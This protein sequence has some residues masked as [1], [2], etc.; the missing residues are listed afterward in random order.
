LDGTGLAIGIACGFTIGLSAGTESGRSDYKKKL[1]K[2]VEAG[3]I[4]I[5]NGAGETVNLDEVDH[6]LKKMKKKQG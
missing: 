3:E 4:R 6:I 2:L 1:R 5:Q